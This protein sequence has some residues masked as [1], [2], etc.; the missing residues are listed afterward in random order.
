MPVSGSQLEAEVSLATRTHPLLDCRGATETEDDQSPDF[1]PFGV[2]G[3]ALSEN[4]LA[5][6][7]GAGS[8]GRR[9][10]DLVICLAAL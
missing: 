8:L 1:Q 6:Q 2:L 10:R 7:G 9:G 5:G 4:A 3:V